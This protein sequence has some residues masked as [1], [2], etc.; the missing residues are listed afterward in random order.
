MAALPARRLPFSP[1]PF[2]TA[3]VAALFAVL[4]VIGTALAANHLEQPSGMRACGP[5]TW[6][7]V[8]SEKCVVIVPMDPSITSFSN[9]HCEALDAACRDD[10]RAP[11]CE[12]ACVRERDGLVRC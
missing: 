6:C 2:L 9:G 3:A 5:S 8:Q 1:A 12:R 7:D 10:V 11:G 4:V